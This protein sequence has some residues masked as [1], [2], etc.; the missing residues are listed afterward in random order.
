MLVRLLLKTV[1]MPVQA[2]DRQISSKNCTMARH[3]K[4]AE[5]LPDAEMSAGKD[6]AVIAKHGSLVHTRQA[7]MWQRD[8]PALHRTAAHGN[9]LCISGHHLAVYSTRHHDQITHCNVFTLFSWL[10]R[11]SR[12]NCCRY[13]MT[14][15]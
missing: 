15:V 9:Y 14:S 6:T 8:C 11:F 13:V 4:K 2:A 3:E 10:Q 7:V 1:L 12:F 5:M